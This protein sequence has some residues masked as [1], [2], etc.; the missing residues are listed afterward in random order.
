MKFHATLFFLFFVL[1]NVNAQGR[2]LYE[3]I[4]NAVHQKVTKDAK[5]KNSFKNYS[6]TFIG[7]NSSITTNKLKNPGL[8]KI[9]H[10]IARKDDDLVFSVYYS[11]DRKDWKKIDVLK[12]GLSFKSETNTDTILTTKS[13]SVDLVGDYYIKFIVDQYHS[14]VFQI[15]SLE[16]FE[17]SSDVI[18]SVNEKIESKLELDK[19]IDRIKKE[20]SSDEIVGQIKDLEKRYA[21]QI[22]NYELL[23]DKTNGIKI[24]YDLILF[25]YDRAQMVSPNQYTDFENI[26]KEL[27]NK[28]DV[29]DSIMVLQLQESLKNP[30]SPKIDRFASIAK[31]GYDIGNIISG[32]KLEGVINSFKSIFARTYSTTNLLIDE[33]QKSQPVGTS[34][35]EKISKD[36]GNVVLSKK[37][38]EKIRAITNNSVK[39]FQRMSNFFSII[40][41]E[42]DHLEEL[43]NNLK[44]S[45]VSFEGYQKSLRTHIKMAYQ[46]I[47]FEISESFIDSLGAADKK[48]KEQIVKK[49]T[50]YFKVLTTSTISNNQ[51]NDYIKYKLDLIYSS[52]RKFEEIE[53]DYYIIITELINTV[54]IFRADLNRENPFFNKPEFTNS[55]KE[56]ADL[57]NNARKRITSTPNDM[58]A[59]YVNYVKNKIKR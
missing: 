48:T 54:S 52:L 37:E 30:P 55:N 5:I 51:N 40:K 14:G 47:E 58:I 24:L 46:V 26:V 33:M 20:L 41:D 12:E 49:T 3:T 53:Q 39:D 13:Y 56:W 45:S 9:S 15:E 29:L 18:N 7:L 19:Q 25:I 4:D 44:T 28:A 36:G 35:F 21:Y 27:A 31:I 16:I 6:L 8:I 11:S 22:E 10:A 42:H 23:L 32:G 59:S 1:L 2:R 43:I 50:D 38:V 17:T 34:L 57:S